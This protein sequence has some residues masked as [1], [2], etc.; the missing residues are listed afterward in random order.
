MD[1]LRQVMI[2]HFLPN[3]P[4]SATHYVFAPKLNFEILINVL[5]KW[6]QAYLT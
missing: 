1:R 2:R 3:A 4:L 6:I 5:Q